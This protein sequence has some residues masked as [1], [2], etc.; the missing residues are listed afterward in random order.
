M[1]ESQIE[2]PESRIPP[3]VVL[4]LASIALGLTPLLDLPTEIPVP[5]LLWLPVIVGLALLVAARKA[6]EGAFLAIPCLSLP[7]GAFLILVCLSV[8]VASHR[9]AALGSLAVWSAGILLFWFMSALART[10]SARRFLTFVLLASGL[11]AAFYGLDQYFFGWDTTRSLLES[12]YGTAREGAPRDQ[13]VAATAGRL[14]MKRAFGP[15]VY[16]NSFAGF[17]ALVI[18]LQLGVL[19]DAVRAR[20]G[21]LVMGVN[22]A[23][24]MA[25]LC[26]MLLT[27]S[28]GGW[29]A[30]LFGLVVSAAVAGR[31]AIGSHARPL[32][33]IALAAVILLAGLLLAGAIEL[34]KLY[35]YWL[36]LETRMDYWRAAGGVIRS[37]PWAGVGAGNFGDHFFRHKTETGEETHH[38]HN[39][40]LEVW[41][42]T[43]ILG[44]AAF[45]WI[46]VAFFA[47]ALRPRGD[48]TTGLQDYRTTRLKDEGTTRDRESVG[49]PLSRSHALTLSRVFA[50]G[51]SQAQA[52]LVGV[53]VFGALILVTGQ[54]NWFYGL[55]FLGVWL[56]FVLLNV[57]GDEAGEGEGL[58][59]AGA[60]GGVAALLLHSLADFP[61]HTPAVALATWAVAALAIGPM[62]EAQV[63]RE[64]VRAS[65]S[66]FHPLTLS[67]P[68]VVAYVPLAALVLAV[69]IRLAAPFTLQGT[70]PPSDEVGAALALEREWRKAPGGDG[71]ARSC[72]SWAVARYQ[73]AIELRPDWAAYR[74]WLGELLLDAAAYDRALLPV[75][76]ERLEEAL[77]RYPNQPR[78]RAKLGRAYE[79]AG[80]PADAQREW[81]KALDL[82]AKLRA[83]DGPMTL[84][85]AETERVELEQKARAKP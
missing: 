61:F 84:R 51:H 49:T 67:R 25:M 43:G 39:E 45:A 11:V 31:R 40:L 32:G 62:S 5:S 21:W 16:P 23:S 76:V 54:I 52:I 70:T 79:Q 50:D 66:R 15:F 30:L 46:W 69:L 73:K 2:N 33:F 72:L 75:A 74:F 7:T 55:V 10:P 34:P 71:K 17:L 83:A 38:A 6:D 60:V 57:E 8:W 48:G 41:A 9:H 82:D 13:L 47:R 14:D 12:L 42:E 44:L 24:A 80:R 28:K 22:G 58:W 59:R 56:V 18:A 29:A 36:S 78:Y 3:R 68:S 27:F 65:L 85:L 64:S 37:H 35:R 19:L 81:T 63:L 4:V 26:A 1:A 53:L 77:A 20:R